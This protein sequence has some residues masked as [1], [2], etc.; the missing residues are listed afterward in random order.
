MADPL[1]RLLRLRRQAVEQRRLALADCL[2]TEVDAAAAIAAID[3]RLHLDQR[4]AAD[5]LWNEPRFAT[6]TGPGRERSQT[7]RAAALAALAEAEARSAA[8]RAQLAAAR[9]EAEAVASLLDARAE[10]AR[11]LAERQAEHALDDVVR[12]RLMRSRPGRHQ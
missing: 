2:R 8:A 7:Q 12:S 9:A 3:A 5:L 11:R 6:M 4:A 1:Q 10:L